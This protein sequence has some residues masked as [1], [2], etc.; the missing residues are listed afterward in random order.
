MNVLD[1]SIANVSIPAIM[2]DLAIRPTG[3]HVGHYVIWCRQRF[4]CRSP[5][6]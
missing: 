2:G 3:A 1:T 4:R 5:A 6:G